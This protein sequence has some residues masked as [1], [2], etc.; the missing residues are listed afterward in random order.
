MVFIDQL[1][2]VFSHETQSKQRFNYVV[3]F[4][5]TTVDNAF[6]SP[7]LFI[8]CSL[9]SHESCLFRRLEARLKSFLGKMR[10]PVLT[11]SF[12]LFL[13]RAGGFVRNDCFCGIGNDE[14]RRITKGVITE[15]WK[16]P[17]MVLILTKYNK[18]YCGGA[19]ISDRH[20]NE[21]K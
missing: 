9:Y 8:H 15:P 19:L 2:N 12:T 11:L 13:V 14:G 1:A 4:A 6:E 17:W 16:Y 5:S 7:T 10:N 20:V 18:A 3:I 21:N